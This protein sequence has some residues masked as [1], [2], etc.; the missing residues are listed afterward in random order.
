MIKKRVLQNCWKWFALVAILGAILTG[1]AFGAVTKPKDF[2]TVNLFVT[3]TSCKNTE[4]KQLTETATNAYVTVSHY[5][6][7]SK[8]YKEALATSGM[9]LGDILI[10]PQSLFPQKSAHKDYAPLT[11]EILSKYSVRCEELKFLTSEED[12]QPYALTVYDKENNVDLF[13]DLISF[14]GEEEPYVLLISKTRPNASPFSTAKFTS[15][16]AFKAL[17]ALLNR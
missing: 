15:D 7:D 6:I 1:A 5:R 16:N 8:G 4:V 14:D 11:E 12:G 17:A 2:E 3:S 13:K 9:L 10:L